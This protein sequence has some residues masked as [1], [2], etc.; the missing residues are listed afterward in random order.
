[1]VD[2]RYTE[3]ID[4]WSTGCLLY[5][6]LGGYPPFSDKSHKGLFRKIRGADFC[7]HDVHWKHVSAAS[8][9]LI[10]S[11]LVVDP[12]HRCTATQALES[13]WFQ[14]SAAALSK[15]DLSA[16]LGEIKLFHARRQF[17]GAVHAV[18]LSLWLGGRPKSTTDITQ[19]QQQ[20]Q[21]RRGRPRWTACSANNATSLEPTNTMPHTTF[22][23]TYTLHQAV[24]PTSWQ[25]QNKYTSQVCTVKIIPRLLETTETKTANGRTLTE[26]VLHEA[27]ILD[28]LEHERIVQFVDFFEED[29]AFY[30]VTERLYGGD[31]LEALQKQRFCEK[32]ARTLAQSLLQAVA[33][34]HDQRVAHRDLKPQNLQLVSSDSLE[35]KIA[36]FGFACRVHMAKSLT[37][38]CG[39]TLYAH[40]RKKNG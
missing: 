40:D 25:C 17:K 38:R 30:M 10:A 20:S 24:G 28:S 35:L 8:K 29:E 34:L 36:D 3:R 32:D 31:L 14:M 19:L 9:Q 15:T 26:A 16:S 22:A 21:I 4:Y 5:M 6:L 1:M 39:S 37:T 13:S 23:E 7:F 12:N 33:Y 2:V 27:A 18:Q 11:L